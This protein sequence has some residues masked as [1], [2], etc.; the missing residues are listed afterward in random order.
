MAFNSANDLLVSWMVSSDSDGIYTPGDWDAM[1]VWVEEFS[2][3]GAVLIAPWEVSNGIPLHTPSPTNIAPGFQGRPQVAVDADGDF[4][5]VYEGAAYDVATADLV[6]GGGASLLA[7]FESNFFA[8]YPT[9][10]PTLIQ[11]LA[12][13]L[14]ISQGATVNLL[15]T[16]GT[17]VLNWL[18]YQSSGLTDSMD[19]DVLIND[20]LAQANDALTTAGIAT[21]SQINALLG[22]L[23]TMS[24]YSIGLLRGQ[25]DAVQY[26]QVDANAESG[27]Y[28]F[29]VS[30][31][32]ANVDRS[33]SN[34]TDNIV[35]GSEITGGS[36]TISV[37]N[38]GTTSDVT[39]TPTFFRK[40]RRS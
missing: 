10:D 32:I 3:T 30:D 24:E 26:T 27:D 28:G 40:F 2:A 14:G 36:F 12:S 5:V 20:Y 17:N 11:D 15:Q 4:T 35:I 38:A 9:Y 29:L 23:K 34:Q 16:W 33:G 25:Y 21:P 7:T 37:T 18:G 6:S 19:I 8:D 13:A 39:I 22:R 31:A 1:G